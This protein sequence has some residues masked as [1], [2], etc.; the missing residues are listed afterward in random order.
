[1]SPPPLR[2]QVLDRLP[3][4][5]VDLLAEIEAFAGVQVQFAGLKAP[6]SPTDPDPF[7]PENNVS[8]TYAIIR[9][10][11]VTR[12]TPEGL[13]HELLHIQRYWVEGIPQLY[14]RPPNDVPGN[15]KT[16][17]DVENTLEHMVIVPRQA[18]LGV[19]DADHWNVNAARI[20]GGYPW[21]D[22]S[23]PWARRLVVLM[24]RLA[25][26]NVTAPQVHAQARIAMEG[27][28]LAGE[29]DRFAARISALQSGADPLAAKAQVAACAARFLKIPANQLCLLRFDVRNRQRL[30]RDL[31]AH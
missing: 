25:L 19:P 21:V 29:A 27:E 2:E 24:N 16:S 11:D 9:F 8:D 5:G 7:G 31:P 14:P 18:N 1:M 10:P 28:G 17:G 15:L 23:T 3:Q 4:V 22:I 12:L 20:W 13:V 6:R 30:M 26:N